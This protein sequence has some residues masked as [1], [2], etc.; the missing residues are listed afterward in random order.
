M[1]A[2]TRERS[3]QMSKA[4]NSSLQ[5][6]FELTILGSIYRFFEANKEKYNG[7]F[8]LLLRAEY[9][10]NLGTFDDYIHQIELEHMVKMFSQELEATKTFKKF[11]IP[12]DV[13]LA[14]VEEKDTERRKN[15]CK[16]H[17]CK[18]IREDSYLSENA[19]NYVIRMIGIEYDIWEA[20]AKELGK[21]TEEV[22]ELFN[23]AVMRRNAIVHQMDMND[24]T[25]L[26]NNITKD[27]V[28]NLIKLI[29]VIRS[30]IEKGSTDIIKGKE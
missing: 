16:D 8:D 30:K 13:V 10:L 22:K 28:D 12:M 1:L 20:S 21:T 11:Q 23:K 25:G 27:D 2:Y 6:N 4:Y 7:D 26:R 5:G 19:V 29:A 24:K 18:R 14:I 9:A 3:Q 17:F 15:I